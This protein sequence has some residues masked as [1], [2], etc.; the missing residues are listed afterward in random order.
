[1][2]KIKEE[3]KRNGACKQF[4]VNMIATLLFYT[5]ALTAF[6]DD[7]KAGRDTSIVVAMMA[8]AAVL[9]VL[10]ITA[11]GFICLKEKGTTKSNRRK[12]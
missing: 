6:M 12:K 9:A 5:A 10:V 4:V 3:M 7:V 11:N 8:A 2:L 1:M